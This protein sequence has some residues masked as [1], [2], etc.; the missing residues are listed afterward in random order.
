MPCRFY[1]VWRDPSDP[2]E[3]RRHFR[4]H[5]F[6]ADGSVE[7]RPEYRTNDGHDHYP[8]LVSRQLLPREHHPGTCMETVQGVRV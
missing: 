6:L 4:V 5:L 3:E 7:V 1:G 2:L 8:T